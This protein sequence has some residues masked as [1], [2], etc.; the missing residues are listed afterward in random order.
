MMV[1]SAAD[2]AELTSVCTLR[3]RG[4]E[5]TVLEVSLVP[6]RLGRAEW[7][8]LRARVL[9]TFGLAWWSRDVPQDTT[10][11]V[12]PDLQ[13]T[14]ARRA[15][16]S[17]SGIRAGRARGAG[18]ELHQL[19]DYQAGDPP[20][21]I[22]WKASA[23][24]AELITR[25]FTEDQHLDVVVALDAGRSSRLS[26]GSLDR[27]GTFVNVAARFAEHTVAHDDRV[28]LVVYAERV[29]ALVAPTRGRIGVMRVRSALEAIGSSGAESSPLV[30]ALQIRSLARHRSLVVLLTDLDDVTT[31][32]ELTRAVRLLQQKHFVIIA[33][34]SVQEI[35][36]MSSAPAH[37]WLDPY[38]SL[39]ARE[40]QARTRAQL[41]SLRSTGTPVIASR[42]AELEA[43]ILNHYSR[44][45]RE[46]RV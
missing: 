36:A 46:R 14:R 34:V 24:R 38:R 18:A 4:A 23:R 1:Q 30:A 8:T 27:L 20:N 22:D 3:A 25:E 10:I 13:R 43:A 32:G 16:T 28:G 29:L 19:R 40:W 11:D 39:A 7:P 31:G 17:D 5:T 45:R 21:R 37:R 15:T 2:G 41:S 26:A 6:G 9:G 35:D 12:A 33:G 42:P 44:L